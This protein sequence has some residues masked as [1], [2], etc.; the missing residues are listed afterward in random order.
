M[1]TYQLIRNL[2]NTWVDENQAAK[3][4]NVSPEDMSYFLWLGGGAKIPHRWKDQNDPPEY[5][6]YEIAQAIGSECQKVNDQ[7]LWLK[8]ALWVVSI[9]LAFSIL[10]ASI[11]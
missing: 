2:K 7:N 3:I 6:L 10:Y 1:K 5:R 4:F 11:Y 8:V 9:I